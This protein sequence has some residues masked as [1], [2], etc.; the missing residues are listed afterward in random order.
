MLVLKKKTCILLLQIFLLVRNTPFTAL[1]QL[2][3]CLYNFTL[4]LCKRCVTDFFSRPYLELLNYG[5]MLLR[6]RKFEL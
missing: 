4:Q 6:F 1:L 2:V 5:I 3:V